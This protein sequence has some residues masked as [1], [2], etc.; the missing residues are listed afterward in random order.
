ML[1]N[2]YFLILDECNAIPPK[3][4]SSEVTL[5][6]TIYVAYFGPLHIWTGKEQ[7]EY[8]SHQNLEI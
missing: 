7:W 6:N 4:S 8:I 1:Y 2:G 5:S 3:A